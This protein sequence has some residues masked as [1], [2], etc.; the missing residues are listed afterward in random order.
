M[1][2]DGEE[3]DVKTAITYIRLIREIENPT[4]DGFDR[5]MKAI[6][7]ENAEG[8]DEGARIEMDVPKEFRV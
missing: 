2:A 5:L 7:E 4:P 1:L 3:I 6:G 8:N